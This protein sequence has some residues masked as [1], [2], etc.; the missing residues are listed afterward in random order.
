VYFD[1]QHFDRSHGNVLDAP[2]LHWN[3]AFD[4]Q[5]QAG[6]HCLCVSLFSGIVFRFGI[7][8]INTVCA[9]LLHAC[10]L[11]FC[12]IL[13]VLWV[14]FTQVVQ[15]ADPVGGA[16]LVPGKERVSE[17]ERERERERGLTTASALPSG[18][19]CGS[20]LPPRSVAHAGCVFGSLFRSI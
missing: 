20:S 18:Q 12:L 19:A 1:T 13:S 4:P 10:L 5:L 3:R 7:G 2:T 6:E 14:M 17:R 15:V 16:A 8:T 11:V 9:L